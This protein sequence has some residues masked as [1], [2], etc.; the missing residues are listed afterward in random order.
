M[1]AGTD[2]YDTLGISRS[3]TDDEIRA[4]FRSLARK[5]HP[6][7]SKEPDSEKRFAEV[8]EAYEVLSDTEKR[9]A[10]DRFGHAGSAAAGGAPGGGGW[11]YRGRGGQEGDPA[12]FQEIFE[13]MF[14][15]Q[16][17]RSD[18]FSA[19][20]RRPR[21]GADVSQSVTVTFL[22]AALGGEESVTL[23]DGTSVS[24]R[25][26]AGIEDGGR[27]RIREKGAPGPDGGPPGDVIVTVRVG[28]HPFF[29]RAGLD[30]LIDVPISLVEAVRGT[31]VSI[32]LLQGAVDLRIPAG[33]SSGRKLRIGGKG[34]TDPSGRQGDF[35]AIVQIRAPEAETLSE[36]GQSALD[37]LSAE[38]PDPREGLF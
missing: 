23:G 36:A 34:I 5:Y 30:L 15:G 21:R 26:P 13:E 10:Y 14:R 24:L 25:I 4:A 6:D 2:Y 28:G 27:L 38:L 11:D 22:T 31:A 29:R 7:V 32:P 37:T 9:Q 1:A 12:A 8:Q 3:A 17:G 20:D 16:G 19:G 35:Y 18:P 33:S